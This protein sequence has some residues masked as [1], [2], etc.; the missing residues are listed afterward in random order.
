VGIEGLRVLGSLD[1]P[2]DDPSATAR[3]YMIANVE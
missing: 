1:L 3:E 2:D